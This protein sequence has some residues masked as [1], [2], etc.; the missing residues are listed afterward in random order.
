MYSNYFG[1]KEPSFSIAPDPQFLFLSVQH[2]EALAHLLY[3][4]ED[5]GGFV[6]LT[7]EVGTGKTTVCHAFL[8]QLPAGVEVA[9]VFNP[10]Q[11]AE[12]LLLT[13]CDEFQI[14]LMSP[15][16]STKYLI[17]QLNHYLLSAHAAGR[18][19]LLVIDEAQNLAPP[20]LEQVRLLTNLETSKHKLLQIFLIGQPELRRSLATE[21]L[22]QLNQRITARCHLLPFGLRETGDYIC[23]RLAIAGVERA[24]FTQ[25]AIREIYRYTG[26]IPRLINIVCDRALLG[27][28]ISHRS[29]VTPR[30]VT[31]AVAEVRGVL[32]VVRRRTHPLL[33]L[34]LWFV[35]SVGAGWWGYRWLD[36]MTANPLEMVAAVLARWSASVPVPVPP[37]PETPPLVADVPELASSLAA[38]ALP[39]ETAMRL[40]LREWGRMETA[41]VSCAQ[42]LTLGLSCTLEVGTVA[43]LRYFDLPALLRVTRADGRREFAVLIDLTESEATLALPTA[44][45]RLPV[46]VLEREWTGNYTLLWQL[47]PGGALLIA[48]GAPAEQVRWLRRMLARVPQLA[49]RADEAHETPVFDE[50]LTELVKTFQRLRGLEADGVAG[51]RTLMQLTHLAEAPGIPHLRASAAPDASAP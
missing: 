36:Q 45:M 41:G 5:H 15:P 40:L 10:M 17:D 33:W 11:T 27:A 6:L 38:L 13:L 39:E 51:A 26:G 14:T 43:N 24:L 49:R 18:R 19:P 8:E 9:F 23:H 34:A 4:A 47:P 31:Q 2:R 3:G 30:I 1:L 21:K 50:E 28:Y 20:V 35:L 22:R 7:G 25:S 32:P 16:Y 44:T 48:P 37:L 12:E 29:R 46:P 42:V